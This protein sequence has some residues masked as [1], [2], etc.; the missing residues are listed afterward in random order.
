[1]TDTETDILAAADRVRAAGPSSARLARDPVNQPMINNW[2][3]A[4][5]DGNPVYSDSSF[6]AASVHGEPVAPPAMVQVWTMRGLHPAPDDDPMGL[7]S[8]ALDAAGFT[9]VV[10]TNCDQAYYRYLRHGERLVV[11]SELL[12]VAGPK[13][14]ALGE[15]WFVTTRST[16]Y[17][18]LI[19]I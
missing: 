8:A 5:G 6:A 12:D 16:W 11:R 14:T 7:M 19:H 1:M 18:S 15:G 17:L 3:E 9:S 2:T 10:A 4:I 13:R